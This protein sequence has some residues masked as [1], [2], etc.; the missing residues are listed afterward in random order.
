MPRIRHLS[1][2]GISIV[3]LLCAAV[4]FSKREDCTVNVSKVVAVDF[5]GPIDVPRS[6]HGSYDLTINVVKDDANVPATFCYTVYDRDPWWKAIWAPDD[7]LAEGKITVPADQT[8]WTVP[9]FF[10][11]VNVDGR[12]AGKRWA[13][14]F[15]SVDGERSLEVYVRVVD[16]E[17]NDVSAV[18]VVRAQ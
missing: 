14:A 6:S 18:K 15:T 1:I 11:L 12:V 13:P 4:A 7:V 5:T 16:A 2:A 17:G 3:L 10:S 8:T 9:G